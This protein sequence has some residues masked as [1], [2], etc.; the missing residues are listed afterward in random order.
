[1]TVELAPGNG[2]A[3]RAPRSSTSTTKTRSQA[4]RAL[5]GGIGV[6]RAIDA[7][8]VDAV[9]PDSG[10]QTFQ[11]QREQIWAKD[12]SEEKASKQWRPGDA[13]S[14]ALEWIVNSVA[15]AGTI[16]V[17]GVYPPAM[18]FFPFGAAFGKNLTMRGGNCNHRKYISMLMHLVASETIDPSVVLTEKQP[19]SKIIDAYRMFDQKKPGWLKVELEIAYTPAGT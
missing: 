9:S 18:Q 15:K 16:A 2:P 14:Q 12:F 7:V 17:I 8:G 4:I 3:A 6:D 10:S 1:M 13:P 5:T 19:F 11:Q